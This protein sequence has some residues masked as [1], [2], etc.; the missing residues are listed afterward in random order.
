MLVQTLVDAQSVSADTQSSAVTLHMPKTIRGIV[1]YRTSSYSGLTNI[2]FKLQGRLSEDMEWIDVANTSKTHTSD[3]TTGVEDITLY[4]LMRCHMNITG[5][6]SVT[7]D[8]QIG[9]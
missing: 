7:V 1:Q 5:T 6:G 8:V 4:P 9:A 3:T 2:I